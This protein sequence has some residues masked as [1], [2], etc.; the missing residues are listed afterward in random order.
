MAAARDAGFLLIDDPLYD[1]RALDAAAH[2]LKARGMRAEAFRRDGA[3]PLYDALQ[4]AYQCV[5]R[6]GAVSG[7]I[8]QGAG[9]DCALALACQLPSDRLVLV[10][11]MR[12][13]DDGP[14]GRQLK[15]IRAFARQN[16]AFCVADALIIPGP[17]TDDR[18][19]KR[20]ARDLGGA[21]T[22]L[23]PA[24]EMWSNGKEVLNLGIFQFLRD[25]VWPKSLAE[26]SEMCIIYG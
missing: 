19:L 18:L 6:D 26:K 16:A 5:R 13:R 17:H 9:C 7:I 20:L 8:A 22:R 10:E 23:R 3:R 2:A 15:R 25:G 1:I 12:W 21:V 4:R 14:V 24:E 11:P